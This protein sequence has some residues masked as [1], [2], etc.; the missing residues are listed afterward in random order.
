[1]DLNSPQD[2]A[3]TGALVPA[4]RPGDDTALEGFKA[5]VRTYLELDQTVR[6]LQAALRARRAALRQLSTRILAF[7]ESHRI[8]D[9]VTN[10]GRL[11]MA[12]RYQR[13]PLTQKL[14][15]ERVASSI[16]P[17]LPADVAQEV[18]QAVLG[19]RERR[20]VFSLQRARA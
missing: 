7:M 6:G 16:E 2:A 10:L 1:M 9:L 3:P 13:P 4:G 15:R 8:N 17:H 12:V 19:G 14:L 20:M 11:R 18:L 5:D